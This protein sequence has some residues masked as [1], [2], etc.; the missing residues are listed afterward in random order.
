MFAAEDFQLLDSP[1]FA[2]LATQMRD[3]SLQN[4]VMWFRR[5]GETLRM[6]APAS[7]VKA[8]NLSN[9]PRCAVLI[10]DPHN[11]YRYIEIRG[12]ADVRQDDGAARAE[13]RL[14]AE[15][16]IGDKADAYVASLSSAPR[17]LIV[18]HTERMRSHSGRRPDPAQSS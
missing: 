10:D 4:T 6:V 2:K 12:R 9:N 1:S 8:R 7:S 15:R 13:L 5:D 14:I 18:I 17:V 16:Y 3:G 11:A